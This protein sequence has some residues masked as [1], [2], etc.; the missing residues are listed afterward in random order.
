[1][2]F[3]NGFSA[4]ITSEGQVLKEY[5]VA[6]DVQLNRVQCWI[7]GEAGK[8]PTTLLLQNCLALT[9]FFDIYRHS[10]YTGVITEVN[11]TLAH[12][13]YWMGIQLLVDF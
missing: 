1:M 9:V 11:R 6:I 5:L 10:Q 7:P 8:V 3:H 12:T 13:L 2:P 4:W